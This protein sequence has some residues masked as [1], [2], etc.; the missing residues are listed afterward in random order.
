MQRSEPV[1]RS[2][3]HPGVVELESPAA[4]TEQ[5][6]EVYVWDLPVRL[7]HWL[8]VASILVLSVTGYFIANPFIQTQGVATDQFLMGTIRFTHYVAAFVFTTSVLFRIYW[9]FRGNQ[10]ARWKQFVPTSRAR[11]RGARGMLRY[12]TF[13]RSNPPAQVGHNPLAGITYTGL[14][15]LFLIQIFTGFALYSLPFHG[16]FWVTMF[17][18]LNLWLGIPYVRLIHT[19]VMW[20]IIAFTIHHVYSATLIDFEERSGLLSSIVTGFK[21][22]TPSHIA[23]AE[24][25]EVKAS[26][27][28]RRF[29]ARMRRKRSNSDV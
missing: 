24:S 12:Y 29:W 25:I 11:L 21:S 18:W 19:I 6:V 16:G 23:E 1:E 17:G 5:K 14:Y 22:L 4:E 9:A 10:Y 8:N 20:L 15:V 28:R 2:S 13:T 3:L 26:P 7:T 27:P